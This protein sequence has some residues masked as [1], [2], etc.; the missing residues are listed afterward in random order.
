MRGGG[1]LRLITQKRRLVCAALFVSVG[2]CA[3]AAT[4]PKTKTA[5]KSTPKVY[6]EDAYYGGDLV[7]IHAGP[8]DAGEHTLVVGPW[9][10]GPRVSPKPSDKRPNLYI[11]IPGT[12]HEIP[13]DPRFNNTAILSLAPDDPKE[14]DVYWVVVFDPSLK[15]EFTTERQ[16]IAERQA[17]FKPPDDFTFDQI[18]SAAFLKAMTK[19]SS[20]DDLKKFRRPNGSLPRLAIIT[21]GF[22][23]RFT[24]EKP[25]EKQA[26]TAPV[27]H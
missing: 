2:V 9:N 18:P 1:K 26:D 21:A 25:E 5:A 20:L 10:L 14:F 12:Q 6:L 17:T 24:V 11:V 19:I 3:S 8:Y 13:G 4:K 22:A 27:E 15:D 23:V 7:K 16:L